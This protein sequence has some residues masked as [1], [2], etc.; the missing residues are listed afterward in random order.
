MC[1]HTY[2]K[3]SEASKNKK[4]KYKSL[5]L[6]A[7]KVSSD[8]EASYSDSDDEEYA[9]AVRDFMKFF[10]KS[11]KFIRQPHDDKKAFRRAK[12]EKKGKVERKCFKCGDLNQFISG[13]HKHSYNDQKAFIGGCWSDSDEDD[14]PK[15]DEICLMV[16]DSNEHILTLTSEVIRMDIPYASLDVEFAFVLSQVIYGLAVQQPPSNS[17]ITIEALS[18]PILHNQW[19]HPSP[20]NTPLTNHASTSAN[21]DPVISPT[22]VEANY[23]VLESLFRERR[24]HICNKDLRTELDYYRSSRVQRQRERVVELKKA[25]NREESR[26]EME[27]DGRRPTERRIEEGGSGGGNLPLL[28]AAHLGRSENGRPL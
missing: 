22:F 19:R 11:G 13:C 17:S 4:E 5:A 3:D 21:L 18:C 2:Q 10:R 14:D 1:F 25:Q 26:V 24:K 16:H 7:K 8:E 9:M 20:K 6:K 28:L 15:K 27:S 12:E 23:E